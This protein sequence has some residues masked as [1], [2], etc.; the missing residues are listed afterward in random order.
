MK[1]LPKI[2]ALL[3][4]LLL[5][6]ISYFTKRHESIL[7]L[8]QYTLL[9][10]LYLFTSNQKEKFSHKEII[11]LAIVFRLS[12]LLL[13]PNLSEDV[14]RFIWDGKMWLN[15]LDSYAMLPSE[16]ADF[17]Y[18]GLSEE[19]FHQL[20]SPGYFTIY[21]PIN[22]LLFYTAALSTS[23]MGSII[24]LRL[25]ILSAEIGTLLLLPQVLKQH[26]L[27]P[28]YAIWYAFNP[29]VILELSGNLHFEA[30]IIFFMLVA[31]YYFYKGANHKS[32]IATGLAI[33]FK[34]IPLILLWGIVK[35]ISFSNWIKYCLIAISVLL[36][37]LLPLMFSD[38]LKGISTSSALY[39]QSFEFNASIYYLVREI[40]FWWKGYNI[41]A[42]SGPWMGILTA[43]C[44][45]SFNLIAK[46]SVTVPERFLWTWFF[47]CLFATTLH[48]WYCLPL[49]IFGLLSGYK[50]PV[51]WTF[52]IFFTY[53]GYTESGFQENLW[54]TFMEYILLF[55]FIVFEVIQ[56]KKSGIVI[57]F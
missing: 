34:F 36:I 15:G 51:L 5:I 26:H 37:T 35:K 30:F 7:L 14:F 29:L 47:Y 24:I 45:I 27:N 33:A 2:A 19:L 10:G 22:Q 39:F 25:F 12:L 41:I 17:G 6:S 53:I 38:A 31:L 48:P 56:K 44:I 13:I 42:T 16:V 46:K 52:L 4:G 18:Y 20:N 57:S 49:V 55:S 11:S 40:G 28:K 1:P 50:F 43:I 54:I 21:P 9:F 32:A 8:S 23:T 3:L